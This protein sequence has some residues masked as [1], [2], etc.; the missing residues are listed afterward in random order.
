[1]YYGIK[2]GINKREI[3]DRYEQMAVIYLEKE[4]YEILERNYRCRY[5]EIDIIGRD[6]Q[7]QETVLVFVE[8]KYRSST[9]FGSPFEAVDLKKQRTIV[10]TANYYMKERKIDAGTRVRYDVVGI[11]GR[12]IRLIRN[13][14]GGM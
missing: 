10:Q 13:A 2:N 8:V 1:M 6:R 3:G 7:S 4:G 12:E 9:R 14:F 11:L 5:G